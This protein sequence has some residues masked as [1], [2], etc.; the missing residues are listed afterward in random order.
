MNITPLEIRQKT[1]EKKLRGYDKE[2]VDAF[3]QSLSMEWERQVGEMKNLEQRYSDAL[4][5]VDRLREVESSLYKAL[6]TAEDTGA[7][8]VDQASKSADLQR[9]EAKMKSSEILNEAKVQAR[10]LI[11]EAESAVKELNV[12]LRE[13]MKACEA[14]FTQIEN[15]R[16]TLLLEL[17]SVSSDLKQRIKKYNEKKTSFKP[18]GTLDSILNSDRVMELK[19]IGEGVELTQETAPKPAPTPVEET[20]IVEEPAATIELEV[21]TAED[22]VED[23]APEE[24][25]DDAD[26]EKGSG[27]FFDQL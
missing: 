25:S 18:T 3:L 27:S 5:D 20:P 19:K 22:V 10:N 8:I 7:N 12:E 26:K 21:E 13:Q 1:F 24:K 23:S 2:E 9:Q 11:E 6:K 17:S 15:Y 16:D 14:D 4:R